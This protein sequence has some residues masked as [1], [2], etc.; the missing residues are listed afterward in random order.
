M[1]VKQLTLSDL[2]NPFVVRQLERYSQQDFPIADII[3][4][5]IEEDT[6]AFMFK[7]GE[8]IVGSVGIFPNV[9]EGEWSVQFA[10]G[11]YNEFPKDGASKILEL[12][13]GRVL[14]ASG[15]SGDGNGF[16][17]SIG[18]VK[19]GTAYACD[20]RSLRAGRPVTNYLKLDAETFVEATEEQRNNIVEMI[21]AGIVEESRYDTIKQSPESTEMLQAVIDGI[22]SG[23]AIGAI[24]LGDNG[25]T[26]II[27]GRY[28]NDNYFNIQGMY[29]PA[30]N[31]LNGIGAE[32]VRA[33]AQVFNEHEVVRAGV[34][35]GNVASECV[36][37]K[38][39][40]SVEQTLYH[41]VGE[42]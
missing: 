31:R 28:V 40:F 39:G 12:I 22:E 32:L 29:V 18:M 8:R 21:K 17:Q 26:G 30:A 41:C 10:V 36:F 24:M 3:R 5:A 15:V 35:S 16:A 6:Q 20:T 37:D 2:D 1:D 11:D 42:E 19:T 33:I 4:R 25:P 38:L 23:E 7:D 34:L 27:I 14:T 13:C 9:Q